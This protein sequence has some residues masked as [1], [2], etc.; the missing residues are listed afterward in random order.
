MRPDPQN[1]APPLSNDHTDPKE[2]GDYS[3]WERA[4]PLYS[5]MGSNGAWGQAVVSVFF[6]L[7]AN[8]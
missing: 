3:N 7:N 4:S 2:G 1:L 8:K 6:T 5:H